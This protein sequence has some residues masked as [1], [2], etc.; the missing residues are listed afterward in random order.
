MS[1]QPGSLRWLDRGSGREPCSL[2]E[3]LTASP[4]LLRHRPGHWVRRTLVKSW[5]W[6]DATGPHFRP[7]KD[8]YSTSVFIHSPLYLFTHEVMYPAICPPILLLLYPC[9]LLVLH[10][11]IHR[12]IHIFVNTHN[13][14]VINP[15]ILLPF[16]SFPIH[17]PSFYSS[18]FQTPFSIHLC[19]L[20]P[21]HHP[22][23]LLFS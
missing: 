17:S 15:S 4:R 9:I 21:T 10:P 12:A 7:P 20:P 18:V 11:F 23:F 19:I 22:D 13:H 16:L 3:E 5:E 6:C 2:G 1:F 8:W 14:P